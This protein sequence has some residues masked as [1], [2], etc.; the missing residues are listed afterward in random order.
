MSKIYIRH[1]YDDLSSAMG[2]AGLVGHGRKLCIV[3][4][5]NVAQ[6]YL[7]TVCQ[8]LG[9]VPSFVFE[10]GEAQ[11]HLGTIQ[12]MYSFFLA[13]KLDRKSVVIALG[14]GVVGDMAGF[15]AATYMRGV[16]VVQLPTSLLAQ[17]DASV[18]GKTGVDFSGVKNLVGAFHQPEMVYMNLATLNTLP[19]D[20]FVSGMGEV[21]KHGLIGDASYYKYLQDNREAIKLLE[22]TAIHEVVEGSYRIKSAVVAAD[23][24]EAGPREVLNFGHCVGHA[25]E[26]LLHYTVPHGKCVAMGMYVAMRLSRLSQDDIDRAVQLLVFFGLPTEMKDC[27]LEDI[28]PKDILP[29]DILDYMY[30]DKKTQSDTLRIVLLKKIGEAY[31]DNTISNKRILECLSD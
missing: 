30:K 29:K 31:T 26:S 6:L 23:E 8:A 7:D 5:S 11:K 14:G 17:V 13:N 24:K 20:E 4:D 21:I 12:D 1:S 15:A 27:A 9:K 10:A 25:I 3:S 19:E 18:G 16:S 28:L 2:K 22:P